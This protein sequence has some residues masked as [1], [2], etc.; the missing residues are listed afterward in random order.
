MKYVLTLCL[1][2]FCLP[3]FAQAA[4]IAAGKKMYEQ[5]C[6]HCHLTTYDDKFGPGLGGIA[7]RVDE[8]WLHKFLANPGEMTKHDEYA[9]MLK[10]NNDY[11]L[12]MPAIPA[13]KNAQ[14]RANVIAYIMSLP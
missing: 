5:V 13:M 1:G 14:K 2:L 9:Q 12:T 7:E 3:H 11:N 8:V 10:E 6:S 4:D